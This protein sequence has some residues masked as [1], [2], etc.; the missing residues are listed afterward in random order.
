M[1][2]S[3]AWR[4][5][6]S[7]AVIASAHLPPE[8]FPRLLSLAHTGLIARL[9]ELDLSGEAADPF[10]VPAVPDEVRALPLMAAPLLRVLILSPAHC[11]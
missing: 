5:A 1:E 8:H 10:G 2:V 9:T 4:R 6:S 3:R 7:S 11:L